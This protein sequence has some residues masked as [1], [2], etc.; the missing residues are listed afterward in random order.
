MPDR[1]LQTGVARHILVRLRLESVCTSYLLFLMVMTTKPAL[2]EAARFSG[3]HTSQCSQVLKYHSNVAIYTL[4][5][6]S[7]KQDKHVAKA[8]QK[9][10]G[11]PWKIALIV[12]IDVQVCFRNLRSLLEFESALFTVKPKKI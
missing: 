11:L 7:K 8:L 2:E 3:L 4:E 12:D 9:C 6:L 10:K 1:T 5:S